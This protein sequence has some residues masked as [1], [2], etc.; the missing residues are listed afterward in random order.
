MFAALAVTTIQISLIYSQSPFAGTSPMD[1]SAIQFARAQQ[2]MPWYSFY[3]QNML[4]LEQGCLFVLDAVLL[5]AATFFL[6]SIMDD[7]GQ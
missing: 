6:F 3:N 4:F 7:L 2:G 5:Y 1:V